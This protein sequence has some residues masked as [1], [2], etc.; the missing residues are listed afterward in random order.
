MTRDWELIRRI[1]R[2]L[3]ERPT[4]NSRVEPAAFAHDDPL[5]VAHHIRLLRD[6]GLIE[7]VCREAT[8]APLYCVAT[9]LTWD[10]YELLDRIRSDTLWARIVEH[11]RAQRIELTIEAI[12]AASSAL[13]QRA[14]L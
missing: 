9:G 1:L 10:G 4:P 11:L 12:R 2:A 6:A 8:G 14:L 13:I 5:I 3:E 7:A